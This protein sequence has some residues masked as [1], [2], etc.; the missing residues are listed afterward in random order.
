MNETLTTPKTKESRS[1]TVVVGVVVGVV[2]LIVV[3]LIGLRMGVHSFGGLGDGLR[4]GEPAPEFEIPSLDGNSLVS[5]DQME[6]KPVW[7][8]FWAS[9]CPPC[10]VEMPDLDELVSPAHGQDFNYLAVS[11]GEDPQLVREY[12]ARTGYD[13]PV[14]V[15]PTSEVAISYGVVGLP[16]HIF[17]DSD[18]VVTDIYSGVLKRG[19]ID[20]L[21]VDLW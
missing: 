19:Q 3:A 7:L 5:L 17:I 6:G 16:T 11:F 10:R 20:K 13:L 21:T 18:G 9:W 4:V 14:G 1:Q 15:N 8:T 12:M 2:V